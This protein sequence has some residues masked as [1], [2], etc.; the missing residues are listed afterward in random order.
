MRATIRGASSALTF[1]IEFAGDRRVFGEAAAGE[2]VIALD[3][4]AVVVHRHARADEADVADV[5]LRAGMMA[6]GEMNVDWR[7][8]RR[9]RL[10]KGG[11]LFGVALGV[12]SGETTAEIAGAGYD[13]GANRRGFRGE[14]QRLDRID[15]PATCASATPVIRRFCHT[16]SRRPPSPNSRAISAR[17]CVCPAVRRPRG[18]ATPIQLSPAAFADE[19]RYAPARS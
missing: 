14:P 6:A 5:M 4:V 1:L 3:R 8:D 18:R 17:P 19:R 11:D 9:R 10:A 16:V 15:A 12:G 13:A 2:N 7:V